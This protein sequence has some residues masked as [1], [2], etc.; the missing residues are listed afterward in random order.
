MSTPNNKN[1]CTVTSCPYIKEQEGEKVESV[2]YISYIFSVVIFKQC[3]YIIEKIKTSFALP[4]IFKQV[5]NQIDNL[6]LRALESLVTSKRIRN[7][8][9]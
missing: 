2:E 5:N 7:F 8:Q 1:W 3:E 9:R 4:Y 6:I